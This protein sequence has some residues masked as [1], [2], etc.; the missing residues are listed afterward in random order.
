M[1][2]LLEIVNYIYEK[3]PKI[4]ELSK[5]RLVKLI[6]LIDWKTAI[7]NG[8]QYTDIKWYFNHYGPYVDDVINMI[9]NQPEFFTV[10]SSPTAYGGASD[11]ITRIKSLP[12]NLDN[13]AKRS[14]DFIIEKTWK[15]NWS[16]FISFVY[17]TYPIRNNPKYTFLDLKKEALRFKSSHSS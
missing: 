3:Y 13:S 5:P 10:N 16:E 8:D 6:F 14:A 12:I 11:K 17:S 1:S 2:K 7:D 4:E 9:K 15:L